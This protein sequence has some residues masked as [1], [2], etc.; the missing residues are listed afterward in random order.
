MNQI[1][2][3]IM[4][5]GCHQ[6]H[7]VKSGEKVIISIHQTHKGEPYGNIFSVL[8]YPYPEDKAIRD[9]LISSLL[10]RK[11]NLSGYART[12]IAEALD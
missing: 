4:Y 6:I 12:F 1:I 11:D 10:K 9:E 5:R 8:A 7:P 2:Q 3:E